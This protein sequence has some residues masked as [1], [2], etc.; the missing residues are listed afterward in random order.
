M[1]EHSQRAA[2]PL[3]DP[4][5]CGEN[6]LQLCSSLKIIALS[7][8]VVEE[9]EVAEISSAQVGLV[10]LLAPRAAAKLRVQALVNAAADPDRADRHGG[11]PLRAAVLRTLLDANANQEPDSQ[12]I[13]PLCAAAAAKPRKLELAPAAR[14][15]PKQY[16]VIRSGNN[17]KAVRSLG[18]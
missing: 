8:T 13:T 18:F 9:V 5:P 17:L 2:P 7:G 14:G 16:Q 6:R 3:D 4:S 12:G 11:T 1:D 10:A 15:C